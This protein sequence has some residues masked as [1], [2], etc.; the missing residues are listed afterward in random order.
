MADEIERKRCGHC[1]A[2]T[3]PGIDRCAV[4]GIERNRNKRDL[5]PEQRKVRRHARVLR[6][7]AMLH[8]IGA[9]AI[10]MLMLCDPL[11]P[12]AGVLLGVIN[13]ILAFGLARYAGWAYRMAI[14]FYFLIGMVN[15]VS[16]NLPAVLLILLLLYA[17]GNG[18]ARALFERQLQ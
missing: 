4:C 10:C 6:S 5:S 8:L 3:D 7:V 1:L 11:P 13:A 14:G 2:V 9:G 12:A 16:V 15:I 17:V 18:T